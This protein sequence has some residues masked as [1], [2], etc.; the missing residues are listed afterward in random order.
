MDGDRGPVW[1]EGCPAN[2][3]DSSSDESCFFLVSSATQNRQ[4]NCFLGN[5]LSFSHAK[6]VHISVILAM[7]IYGCESDHITEASKAETFSQTTLVRR[8]FE[9]NIPER[10]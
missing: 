1:V 6:I 3:F 2:T 7:M 8:V 9:E 5:F 10:A 4:R